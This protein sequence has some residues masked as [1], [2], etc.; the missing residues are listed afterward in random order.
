MDSIIKSTILIL[1]ALLGIPAGIL[2]SKYA[3][4]ELK[5]GKKWFRLTMI[6]SAAIFACSFLVRDDELQMIIMPVAAFIF[7]LSY[8]SFRK[9]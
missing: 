1:I 8:I 5:A 7:L 9:A 4:S 3:K 6:L 2:I